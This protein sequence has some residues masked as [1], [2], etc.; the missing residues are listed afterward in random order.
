MMRMMMMMMI[1][2]IIKNACIFRRKL[3]FLKKRIVGGV[4]IYG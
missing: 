3:S 1:I 2:R 4:L